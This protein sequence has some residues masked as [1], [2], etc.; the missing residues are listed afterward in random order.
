M[1]I[2]AP[3]RVTEEQRKKLGANGLNLAWSLQ[4]SGWGRELWLVLAGI[5]FGLTATSL[6]AVVAGSAERPS[7]RD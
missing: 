5:V 7:A 2:Q 3:L 4:W 1:N 6:V